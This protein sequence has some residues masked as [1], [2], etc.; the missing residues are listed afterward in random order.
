ML[1][2]CSSDNR[3]CCAYSNLL[4]LCLLARH[5]RLQEVSAAIQTIVWS[6]MFNI[7]SN[8]SELHIEHWTAVVSHLSQT[9]L[10]STWPQVATIS[11]YFCRGITFSLD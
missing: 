11:C 1:G 9:V 10:L 8:L 2:E 5:I 7:P 4:Y 6:N 3:M